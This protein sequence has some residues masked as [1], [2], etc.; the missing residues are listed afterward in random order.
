MPGVWCR[1]VFIDCASSSAV[2]LGASGAGDDADANGTTAACDEGDTI[3][4]S[5]RD[6]AM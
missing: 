3:G 6:H 1:A 4:V 2:I 5:E